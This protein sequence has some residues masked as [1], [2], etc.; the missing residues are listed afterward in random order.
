MPREI[1]VL[2]IETTGLNPKE[3]L[4][5]EL[6]MVKLNLESGEIT[7][8]FDQV[9]KDP[10]LTAKHRKAWIFENGF[11][12][13]EEIRNALPIS[14]YF[15][16]IQSLLDPFKGQ[17]TAW[18]RDFDSAFLLKYGFDL[19]PEIK[20]PM[21]ES[22]EYFKIEGNYGYKWPKAQEAWDI[23]FPDTPKVEEHRGLDDSK[24]EATI[25]YELYNKG[26][27]QL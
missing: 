18:N 8:L 21:K 7:V 2:D 27:Y 5:L 23:L 17:I 19:G 12:Q 11:M 14:E 13:I 26:H 15:D 9:F 3:D 1:I 22:V 10:K 25:I 16:E 20:C 24:M 4:I 6:G